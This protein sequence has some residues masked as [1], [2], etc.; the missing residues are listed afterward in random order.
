MRLP[1]RVPAALAVACSFLALGA[2]GGDDETD[3]IAPAVAEPAV[4]VRVT[5][6]DDGETVRRAEV[7]LAGIVTPG[8]EVRVN[9]R[10]ARRVRGGRDEPDRFAVRLTLRRGSNTIRVTA[11]K[12]GSKSAERELVLVRR[13]S[14][15]PRR[16]EE[17]ARPEGEVPQPVPQPAPGTG[18]GT[19]PPGQGGAPAPAPTPPD[20][21]QGGPPAP[22]QG[23]PPAPAEP[24][25]DQGGPPAPPPREPEQGGPPAPG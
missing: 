2:C 15:S 24:D 13:R 3:V 22:G 6:H 9:G 14:R 20:P 25:R 12:A 10:R 11:T 19:P 8:A 21:G 7:R 16:D 1:R 23:G 18:D 5:S 4:E 17:P